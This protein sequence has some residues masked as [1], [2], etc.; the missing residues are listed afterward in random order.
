MRI[1]V[2]T[3]HT[4]EI[5]VMAKK[6]VVNKN[7]YSLKHGYNLSIFS[8]RAS[9]RHPSW[10]KIVLIRRLL[11]MFD[12]CVWMDSDC[13][14]NNFSKKLEDKLDKDGVFIR[15]PYS[16]ETNKDKQLINAGVFA[17][18]NCEASTNLLESVWL[19]G[20]DSL[21]T[22]DKRSYSGWPWEQAALCKHI[23][24][25]KGF[26]ILGDMDMNCHPSMAKPDTHVIHYMG[27]RATQEAED[28]AIADID[29]R[30]LVLL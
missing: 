14:F 6:T 29:R 30:N 5:V 8:G 19:E 2:V 28:A 23:L 18:R 21:S 20:K 10:D 15:D 13:I 25:H 26:S 16:D 12:W 27:W 22:V 4:P 3:S 9:D 17:L 7:A 11:P 1:C 24:S